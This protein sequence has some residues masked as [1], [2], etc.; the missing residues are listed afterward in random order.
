MAF[1]I[2][3]PKL[4]LEVPY[5]TIIVSSALCL[6]KKDHIPTKE[7]VIDHAM[8]NNNDL[9]VS[10]SIYSH[11]EDPSVDDL[12]DC[13]RGVIKGLPKRTTYTMTAVFTCRP[14]CTPMLSLSARKIK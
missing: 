5:A 4:G 8:S 3:L 11:Y 1:K 14:K 13:I 7:E 2:V 6:I 12:I 10:K 9:A